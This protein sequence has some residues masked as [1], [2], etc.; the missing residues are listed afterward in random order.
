MGAANVKKLNGTYPKSTEAAVVEVKEPAIRPMILDLNGGV[1]MIMLVDTNGKPSPT[2]RYSSISGKVEQNDYNCPV[3]EWVGAINVSTSMHHRMWVAASNLFKDFEIPVEKEPLKKFIKARGEKGPWYRISN[4]DTKEMLGAVYLPYVLKMVEFLERE[5]DK[6][7]AVIGNATVAPKY[8]GQ[9]FGKVLHLLAAGHFKK[10]GYKTLV[11]DIVGLNTEPEIAV[12][13]SL[14]KEFLVEEYT[15]KGFS[16]VSVL[17][18]MNIIDDKLAAFL[19]TRNCMHVGGKRMTLGEIS[20]TEFT[21]FEMDL[22]SDQIPMLMTA[23][24]A[25]EKYGQHEAAA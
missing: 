12:W 11:S 1:V 21:Q 22:T 15:E 17:E 5:P 3:G 23:E 13:R 14:K 19:N 4:G 18:S 24:E 2:Y 8:V 25:K 20:E 6:E 16:T 7:E 10:L 9:G